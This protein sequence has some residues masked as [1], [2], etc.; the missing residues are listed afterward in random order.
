MKDVRACATLFSRRGGES[1]RRSH[2]LPFN[3]EF[4]FDWIPAFAGMTGWVVAGDDG[5]VVARMTAGVVA[6]MM[7]WGSP[8]SGCFPSSADAAGVVF[9][10]GLFLFSV[11]LIIMSLT[12]G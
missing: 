6:G 2:S 10:R 8:E 11:G 3:K 9:S 4:V 5:G 7:G 12:T 1:R